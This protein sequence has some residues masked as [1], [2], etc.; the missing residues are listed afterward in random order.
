MKK[1]QLL[2]AVLACMVIS[3]KAKREYF[4]SKEQLSLQKKIDSVKVIDSLFTFEKEVKLKVP[5]NL[6]I[7]YNTH[8]FA[9][10]EG[11]V[12]LD[13]MAKD[14]KI[15]DTEGNFVRKF[16]HNGEGPGEFRGINTCY[17]DSKNNIYIYD[18]LLMKISVFDILGN[19]KYYIK[20]KN[21]ENIR[22]LCVNKSGL[23]FVHKTPQ[24]GDFYYVNVYDS[25]GYIK[26]LI[27]GEKA[28]EAYY[29][30]GFLGGGI[31]A[32]DNGDVFETNT[33]SYHINKISP[34]L[35]VEEY[36]EEGA[37]YKELNKEAVQLNQFEKMQ[38]MVA[39]HTDCIYFLSFNNGRNLIRYCIN[40]GVFA[41]NMAQTPS[42]YAETYDNTGNFINNKKGFNDMFSFFNNG[43]IGY[44]SCPVIKKDGSEVIPKIVLYRYKYEK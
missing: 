15:F 9:F 17:V 26:S 44:L 20:T 40:I 33:Y 10:P 22:H 34:D 35:G 42:T 14:I 4:L 18:Q 6:F 11:Y 36:G 1:Y 7:N 30:S 29:F 12:F 38:K 23:I 39:E 5:K 24:P 27:K 41:N 19:L 8:V 31:L 32:L 16:G 3:C 25:N 37:Y 21:N 43:K 28:Y 2:I 13:N